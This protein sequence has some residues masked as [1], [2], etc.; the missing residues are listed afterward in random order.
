ME[1]IVKVIGI[2]HNRSRNALR[3]ACRRLLPALFVLIGA[4]ASAQAEPTVWQ[5]VT[6][7]TA[8]GWIY[9]HVDVE[10]TVGESQ[11]WIINPDG[12]RKSLANESIRRIAAADGR[13][14]TSDVL[15]G[16]AGATPA[17][18]QPA[19]S[20][21]TPQRSRGSYYTTGRIIAP[22]WRP[23][24][25]FRFALSVGAGLG[26][27]SGAYYE[28]LTNGAAVVAGAKL[29]VSDV[30]YLGVD[31]RRLS[32][33]VDD[34]LRTLDFYDPNGNYLGSI[35]DIEVTLT[36]FYFVAGIMTQPAGPTAPI[37]YLEAGLGSVNHHFDFTIVDIQGSFPT[38]TDE[39][40]LGVYM[41]GGGII[42]I[43]PQVGFD[44]NANLM[45]T[46]SGDDDPYDGYDTSA[47]GA[48]LGIGLNLVLLMGR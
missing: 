11:I 27:S 46:G 43:S 45:L 4:T 17:P 23:G 8:T 10:S 33:G 24:P 7:V 15:H 41:S 31:F 47:A 14:I 32:L 18:E 28:G 38:E 19:P 25:R 40:K 6:V 20:P 48:I 13:D 3:R 36:E 35:Q 34:L 30:I 5:N 21:D 39:S 2:A 42:P 12:A 1:V 37:G 29:A 16:Q 9:E 22:G 26:T 44:L